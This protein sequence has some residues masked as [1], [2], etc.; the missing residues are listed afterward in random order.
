MALS[1]EARSFSDSQLR[2]QR[3]RKTFLLAFV[4]VVHR[5]YPQLRI[6][7]QEVKWE[8]SVFSQNTFV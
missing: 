1:L 3:V 6:R 8:E 4:T 5:A 7:G 2:K